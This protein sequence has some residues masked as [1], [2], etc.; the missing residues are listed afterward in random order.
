MGRGG[1]Q[2]QL[3]HLADGLVRRGH[4]IEALAYVRESELDDHLRSAGVRLTVDVQGNRLDKWRRARRWLRQGRF[5]VVHA[6]LIQASSLALL[7]RWPARRPPIVAT[8]FSTATFGGHHLGNRMFLATFALA[9]AVVTETE[10]NHRHLERLVPTLRAKTHV[11]RNGIDAE[12]FAPT[13][14]PRPADRPFTF[15][16]VA[17]V[18][19]VKNP[20]GVI[21]AVAE[22]T[23]RGHTAFRVD[24]YGRM[25]IPGSGEDGREAVAH[26]LAR[27]VGDHVTFHGDTPDV[28]RA[29]RRSDALLLGSFREGF[30]NA[31]SEGMA[32]GLPI[33]VSRVSDLPQVVAEAN[34]G[35]LFDPADAASIADAMER[36]MRTPPEERA[37]MGRRSRELALRWFAMDRFVDRHE[38]LYRE[39]SG[40]AT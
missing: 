19:G 15:C 4:E 14:E 22:L 36:M 3:V 30:P 8:D 29:Y 24:W 5:D 38:A 9:D 34:N 10:V 27:G 37:A 40:R 31:V 6:L 35:H 39:V 13:G 12:R 18:Y 11:I 26:A 17:S 32:C 28:E 7:A 25:G 21:D 20:L 1:A 16:V 23:R 33:V 2:L